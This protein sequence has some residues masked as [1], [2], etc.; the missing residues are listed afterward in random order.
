MNLSSTGKSIEARSIRE[1]GAAANRQSRL[2]A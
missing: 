1:R 2:F